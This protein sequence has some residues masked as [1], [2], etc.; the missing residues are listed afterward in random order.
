M[1]RLSPILAAVLLLGA[2]TAQAKHTKIYV[3]N[4]GSNTVNVIDDQ[5]VN[6]MVRSNGNAEHA[7]VKQQDFAVVAT[8]P[9]G[10]NPIAV[11]ISADGAL[12]YIANLNSNSL[13]II[14]TE[15]DAVVGT[16]SVTTPRDVEATP[17]GRFILV[18]N[19]ST[20][21]VT[22]L[23]ATNYGVVASIPVGVLPC[24]I[25]ITPD[26]SA[27]YVTNRNSNSVSI[28]DLTTFDVTNVAVGAFACDVMLSP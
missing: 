15:L 6:A 9:V 13:S 18:V 23:D 3:A 28:I 20:N 24:A 2:S 8:I 10:A 17:D 7:A 11:G 12:A 27:A 1:T 19:Q 21:R 14:D 26:G 5:R 16:V 22:V 25:A 4:Q